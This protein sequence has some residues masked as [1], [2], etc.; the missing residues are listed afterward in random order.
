MTR[1][2]TWSL[3]LE[4]GAVPNPTAPIEFIDRILSYPAGHYW[5]IWFQRIN[6][7]GRIQIIQSRLPIAG[8]MTAR[9]S[10]MKIFLHPTV[11]WGR[12]VFWFGKALLH[13]FM[14]LAGSGNHRPE[15]EP[16]MNPYGGTAENYTQLD[17]PYM[18]AYQWR[19]SRRPHLEPTMWRQ[20]AN[21]LQPAMM[22]YEYR[23]FSQKV[24]ESGMPLCGEHSGRSTWWDWLFENR[25]NVVRGDA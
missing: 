15:K 8:W 11:N 25:M 6:T 5:D 22:F 24:A 23:E 16:W 17:Y 4:R 1:T 9:K 13:E 20:I 2:I 3:H 7:P 10:E 14:H 19:S 21:Q 18:A 12:Q